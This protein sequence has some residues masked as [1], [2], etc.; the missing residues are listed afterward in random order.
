MPSY[1][2]T[3]LADAA[4]LRGLTTL[5]AQDRATTAALLAPLAEVDARKLEMP[6]QVWSVDPA[7][8]T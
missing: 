7:L 2:L 4:V 8:P 6:S 1:S 3:H 5:V